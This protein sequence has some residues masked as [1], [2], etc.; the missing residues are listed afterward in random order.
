M[1]ECTVRYIYSLLVLEDYGQL[2]ISSRMSP[3]EIR[4]SIS[5]YGCQLIEYP[6]QLE[7]DVVEVENSTPR[8]WN[9]VVPVFTKEEGWADLSME[10]SLIENDRDIMKF[11]LDNIRVR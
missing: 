8:E 7:L 11:E 6:C 10:I 2:S 4:K 1:I 9:V 5:E 3:E